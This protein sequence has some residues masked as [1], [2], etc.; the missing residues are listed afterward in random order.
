MYN[1]L[2]NFI[3]TGKRVFLCERDKNMIEVVL[4]QLVVTDRRKEVTYISVK[5]G[6]TY[7]LDLNKVTRIDITNRIIYTE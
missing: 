1:D 3:L 5:I 4:T 6:L 7:V 2:I